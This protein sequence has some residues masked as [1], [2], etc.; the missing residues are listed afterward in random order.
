[1][2]KTLAPLAALLL[3]AACRAAE[4]PWTDERLARMTLR[5]RAA[6]LVVPAVPTDRPGGDS[7]LA[8]ALAAQGVGGIRL[9][10]GSAAV[11]T[12]R[13]EALQAASPLPLLVLAELDRGA[14][15]GFD[16]AT[17][18]PQAAALAPRLPRGFAAAAAREMRELGVNLALLDAPPPPAPGGLPF[19]SGG[20]E[21]GFGRYLEALAEEGVLTGVRAF[22][23]G[24]ARGEGLPVLAWDGAAAR[25]LHLDPLHGWIRSG[26]AAIA[27]A[28]VAVPALTRDSVPLPASAVLVRGTLRRDLGFAGLVVAE[29]APG[30]PLVRAHGEGGAAVRAVAGGADLVAGVADAGAV[31]DS[32]VA[33]VESGRISAAAVEASVRRVFAAKEALGLGRRTDPGPRPPPVRPTAGQLAAAVPGSAAL[34]AHR[35]A[36]LV[37]GRPPA[38]VLRGCRAVVLVTRPG[39][40]A[41]ALSAALAGAFPGLAHLETGRLALRGPLTAPGVSF[42]AAGAPCVVAASFPHAPLETV[43]RLVPVDTAL[44]GAD[45]LPRRVVWIEFLPAPGAPVPTAP[46]LVVARG[47]GAAAQQAAAAAVAGDAAGAP[48]GTVWPPAPMLRL[49]AP[50]SA[51]MRGDSL[52]AI[53]RR[54]REALADGVFSAA[55][56]AV[57]R[58][59]VLVKLTGYGSV[60]GGPVDPA[61]TVFDIASLTK[62][63]GT[64]SAAMVAVEEGMLELDAPVRRQLSGFRGDGRERVTVRHL[65][66]HTSGLPAGAWLYGG[67]AGPDQALARVQRSR[68]VTPPGER[69]VYSDFGMILLAAA[70]ERAA[71]EPLDRLL[72]RRVF[73]PLGMASTGYLPP[74]EL[75]PGVVPTLASSERP[76]PLDAVVHDGNAFRLGGVAGHAGLFST[77]LDL[78]VFAQTLLNG[79]AYGTQRVFQPATVAE[80]TRMQPD[81]GT[82]ALGWDTPAPLTSAGS[83]F[84]AR[85]FGH[86]GY[87]GTSLWIDPESGLFVVLLTNRTYTK[88]SASDILNLRARVADL[89]ALSIADREVRPRAGSVVAR[90]LEAAGRR[91]R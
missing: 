5:E 42:A 16:G 45:T 50:D 83:Y 80:F 32:L 12:A 22:G 31:I 1:L 2:R 17:E 7:A 6:Q 19:P 26:V 37:L 9:L 73:G 38:E 76:Y 67:T 66:T 59:G 82:R 81:A 24:A 18:L 35:E 47:T 36:L 79:G 78:A 86:T 3:V 62:V 52:A 64:T 11:A 69:S 75:Q 58:R 71:E 51:G 29:L 65:L 74:P 46:S 13:V 70:I 10:G 43:P 21:A 30:S 90:R 91:R 20:E 61:A 56:V 40:G 68:L 28:Q 88:G 15:G 85:S 54:V 33:A 49:L 87:T 25:A 77:A 55:A 14:G 53:D 60:G 84:S 63:V 48:E 23:G 34:E 4:S 57:G 27:P 72:A 44:A 41:A 8:A 89:S 39:A